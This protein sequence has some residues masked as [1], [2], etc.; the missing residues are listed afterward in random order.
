MTTT[1]SV[2]TTNGD[3]SASTTTSSTT[4]TGGSSTV[5][6]TTSPSTTSGSSTIVTTTVPSNVVYLRTASPTVL[7]TTLNGR[8]KSLAE[9]IDQ[10]CN[11][12]DISKEKAEAMKRELKRIDQEASAPS[13]SYS[14]A[15]MVAQDL[16]QI[17]AQYQTVV[18]TEPAY[19]P[20]IN[21]SHF[22]V[23]IG[24]ILQLDDLSVRRAD[25]EARVTKDVIQGRMS[26]SQ[27]SNLRAQL[28]AIGNEQAA[29]NADGNLNFKE[30][31]R[32]YT[33][34]DH[35]ESQIQKIAGKDNR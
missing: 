21:G 11:H 4:T 15:V 5:V 32:L 27:A 12:G 28:D 18:T 23:Y 35:V 33:Q 22:T 6:T 20:I 29:Y 10:A 31:E 8:R 7:V 26:D 30:A 13:I 19:V 24:Q 34:F 1:T 16:D 25:L 9:S 14:K 2:T 3:P 17:G